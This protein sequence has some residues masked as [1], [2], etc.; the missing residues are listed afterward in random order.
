[1]IKMQE[2]EFD[3][4]KI[5]DDIPNCPPHEVVK[6]YCYGTH[7]DYGCIRCK[8]KSYRLEDFTNKT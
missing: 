6:L 1:M 4:I 8:M 5:T 2:D 3:R 7:T